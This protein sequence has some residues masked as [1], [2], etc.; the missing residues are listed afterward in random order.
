MMRVMPD[1]I[2]KPVPGA[3]TAPG[4]GTAPGGPGDLPTAYL[5]GEYRIE[6][7]IGRGGMG[8]VYSAVQPVIERKVAIKVLNAQYSGEPALVRRFIDEARAVNRIRH[9]NIIDIFSFGQLSDGR[10][11]FVME[12]LEG[13]TLAD[14]LE[15]GDL[16]LDEAPV[17]LAQICDALDA[18]HAS[19]IV[20]RDLKPENIWIVTPRRGPSYVKLL[21]FGIAKLVA[22]D[23]QSATQT[24]ML[25][26]TPHYMS[27]EQ[28]HGRGIDHRTDIYAMGVI[29]YR[30][31]AGRMPF[32]GETFTEILAK[33][34]TTMPEP[35]AQVAA[36]P[37]MLSDLIMRCLAKDVADRPQ[38]AAELGAALFSIFGAVA[39]P[40]APGTSGSSPSTTLRESAAE[41]G[42][43]QPGAG[44]GRARRWALLTGGLL[45][46]L[47]AVVTAA[48]LGTRS[49]SGS[50]AAPAGTGPTVIA[51]APLPTPPVVA[52]PP[53]PP[54][55]H[56]STGGQAPSAQAPGEAVGDD[57]AN[58]PARPN[59]PGTGGSKTTKPSRSRASDTGLVT[60][61]PFQ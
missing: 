60:D 28:C 13:S 37:V 42:K 8:V 27:P 19:R 31:Y 51:P 29:L 3:P 14:R 33:Q 7:V 52:A 40:V 58:K 47:I 6:T 54:A 30:L 48:R 44:A 9:A 10:Q 56:P 46:L 61:N 2:S 43:E 59:R 50:A 20:H 26:G 22:A 35:P 38:S 36:V 57:P 34:L 1:E 16:R 41:L 49:G 53:A 39:A 15:R 25:M 32:Q 18:A 11:Y 55:A 21:D 23:N 12:Y 17:Y 4:R 24:G 5:V 45:L